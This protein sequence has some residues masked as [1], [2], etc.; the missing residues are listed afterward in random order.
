MMVKPW[1]LLED[2]DQELY[3]LCERELTRQRQGLELIASENFASPQI[4]AAMA[5]VFM[6][7][8]AEGLP[9]KR[10]YGGCSVT[11]DMERL[12]IE[13]AKKI[14]SAN[15]ANVQPHSGAQANAA[16]LQALAAPNDKILAL[17]LAH[18]GH[19]THGSAVNFSGRFY[20]SHFYGVS[21]HTGTI[22]Y[23]RVAACAQE[24]QPRV[25][26]AGASSYPRRIDF[27]KFHHICKDVGAYLLVDMAH[28]AGLVAAGVHPSP[29]PWADVVT[30]TTHKTLRGPR[31]GLMLWNNS[32][33]SAKLNKGVF[34]GTQGG[35]MQHI[36]V[37]KALCFKEAAQADFIDYQHQTVAN[38]RTLAAEFERQGLKVLTGGTDNHLVLLDLV[39]TKFSGKDAEALLE[40]IAVSVNKNMIPGDK[41]SPMVTSGLRI[42]TPAVTTRGMKEQ[43]MVVIA[44]FIQR[45]F[46]NASNSDY[47]LDL[48]REV[49]A[50]ADKFPVYSEWS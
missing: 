41:R 3:L 38:A 18:G 47:L 43:E 36:I 46:E 12:A 20:Q 50:F 16:A 23:E 17:D 48:K 22:D 11:D 5:N 37:A 39:A 25:V 27:Q 13:R 34:P 14:F 19:L 7:K 10:Y 6:N 42:G 26:I 9:S 33:L 32:E 31:S 29:V 1:Q 2:C 28:I 15:F 24:V 45:A 40:R 35:P 49:E 44:A 21:D 4:I 30:T 8:Y